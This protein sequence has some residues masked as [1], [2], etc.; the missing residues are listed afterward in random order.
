MTL[1]LQHTHPWRVSAREAVTIQNDLRHWV[2]LRDELP[3][4]VQRVA[5]VDVGFEEHGAMT[6]AAVAVL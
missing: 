5:G 4:V 2:V 3:E 6:R 1:T